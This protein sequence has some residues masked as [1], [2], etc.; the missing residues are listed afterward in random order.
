MFGELDQPLGSIKKTWATTV[1]KSHGV[2]PVW[3]DGRLSADCRAQLR[4]IDLRFHDLRREAGS[5]WLE[6]GFFQVH[7]V[8]DLLGHANVSQ[9]DTYLSAKISGLQASMKRY[10]AAR[11]NPVANVAS[12]EQRPLSHDETVESPKEQLH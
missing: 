3:V 1:L 8:R 4:R 9:T 2:K 11:G 7:D 6:T 5:R 12:M 10:D